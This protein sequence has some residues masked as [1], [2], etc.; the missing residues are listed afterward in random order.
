MKKILSIQSHVAYGY[1]GNKAAVFPLQLMGY[2]VIAIN[3]VQFSNHTGYGQWAG[4]IFSRSHIEELLQHIEKQGLLSQIDGVLSG[5]L[6]DAELGETILEYVSKIKKI[7]ENLVYCCDPVMG[8][9][10][11][12]FFVNENIPPFFKN[13]ALESARIITP[14]QFELAA[15]TEIELSSTTEIIKACTQIHDKGPEIILLTSLETKETP[16]GHIQMLASQKD[17]YQWVVTTPKIEF[18]TPPNG[19]GDLTAAVFTGHILQG[20][21]PGQ[22]L[23]KT[24][25]S[26]FDILKLT[27]EKDAREL[28][29]IEGQK[30]ILSPQ[31]QNAKPQQL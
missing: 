1:V 16:A 7:N 10:G 2:D 15:L 14:N 27:K 23:E 29:L 17:G 12:G 13:K 8:D 24:C 28:S 20:T 9:T 21:H 26:I 25:A 18:E 19:A 4:E 31:Y 5:Y 3:T 30:F 6:G 11:R 22:A